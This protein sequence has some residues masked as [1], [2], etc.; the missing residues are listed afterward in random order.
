[1]LVDKRTGQVLSDSNAEKKPIQI[2][3]WLC[4][5]PEQGLHLP[6]TPLMG[7]AIAILG[8]ALWNGSS[9][10]VGVIGAELDLLSQVI[11]TLIWIAFL[12][13][14]LWQISRRILASVLLIGEQ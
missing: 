5:S 8:H 9:W 4:S 11:M 14:A 1:M 3:R 10:A 7:I 6:T 12:I 13:L 2:P